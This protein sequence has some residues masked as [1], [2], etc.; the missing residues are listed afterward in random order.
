MKGGGPHWPSI[1]QTMTTYASPS[2]EPQAVLPYERFCRRVWFR[3][4]ACLLGLVMAGSVECVAD[5]PLALFG[6]QPGYGLDFSRDALGFGSYGGAGLGVRLGTYLP[7]EDLGFSALTECA[8]SDLFLVRGGLFAMPPRFVSPDEVYR[9]DNQPY[10]CGSYAAGMVRLSLADTGVSLFRRY[11]FRDNPFD[12]PTAEGPWP[13]RAQ[14]ENIIILIHGWN[15]KGRADQYAS[16][17]E[18]YGDAFKNLSDALENNT[19]G[20][21]VLKYHWEADADTGG[22]LGLPNNAIEAALASFQHGLHLGDLLVRKGPNLRKVHFVAHSAGSWMARTAAKYLLDRDPLVS[23]T[24]TLLDPFIPGAADGPSGFIDLSNQRMSRLS[25]YSSEGR[26]RLQNYYSEDDKGL[27][28]L[29]GTQEVFGWQAPYGNE[30]E[31]NWGTWSGP[32]AH[33]DGPIQFY[34]DTIQASKPGSSIPVNLMG[35][36]YD[37]TKVGWPLSPAFLEPQTP[38]IAEVPPDQSVEIGKRITFPCRVGGAEAIELFKDRQF[39]ERDDLG[40]FEFIA[41]AQSS[42]TYVV[43]AR[44][45]A[46]HAYS[47][48]IRVTAVPRGSGIAIAQQPQ[49]AVVTV[50][51]RATFRVTA[52]GKDL[53]YQWYRNG[54]PIEGGTESSWLTSAT[55][56]SNNGYTYHVVVRNPNG[57]VRSQTATLTVVPPLAPATGGIAVFLQPQDAV[58]R[59]A[60]WSIGGPLSYSSGK[61]L[62]G[63]TPGIYQLRF[64]SVPGFIHPQPRSVTVQ[65][66]V[67]TTVTEVYLPE[68]SANLAVGGRGQLV[69]NGSANP[70]EADG[71]AWGALGLDSPPSQRPFTLTSLGTKDLI[72]DDV[73]PITIIGDSDFRVVTQPA[74]RLSPGQISDFVLEFKPRGPGLRSAQVRIAN[75]S[76]GKNPYTFTVS[77]DVSAV[78]SLAVSGLSNPI[79]PDQPA[80]TVSGTDFGIVANGQTVT[81]TFVLRNQGTA[82]LRFTRAVNVEPTSSGF[83]LAVAPDTQA[84]A[85]GKDLEIR[86][87]FTPRATGVQQGVLN[88]ESNDPRRPL[89]SIPLKA[90][91]NGLVSPRG[92]FRGGWVV[93][94]TP[95]RSIFKGPGFNHPVESIVTWNDVALTKLIG[96]VVDG[97]ESVDEMLWW[98]VL[99]EGSEGIGWVGELEENGTPALS[100]WPKPEPPRIEVTYGS[101]PVVNGEPASRTT[102]TDYGPADFRRGPVA[103]GSVTVYNRGDQHL[104]FTEPPRIQGPTGFAISKMPSVTVLRKGDSSITVVTAHLNALGEASCELV[105]PTNDPQTPTFRIPLRVRSVLFPPPQVEGMRFQ[106]DGRPVLVLHGEVDQGVRI[107]SSADLEHWILLDEGRFGP[108]RI[109]EFIDY[110]SISRTNRFYRIH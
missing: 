73:S 109:A 19:A 10:Q 63:L 12:L 71:T 76:P 74:T 92:V 2:P 103:L 99:W 56:L 39:V 18:D 21:K 25:D 26:L 1:Q 79:L 58:L 48:N 36:P 44:N 15:R 3:C 32:Y 86:V 96:Q 47:R 59:G 41:D 51:E 97:P 31:V 22:E 16:H 69:P 91:V 67:V 98:K 80:S 102:G 68:P 9:P 77:A 45:I 83:V 64:L 70:N 24:V 107:E 104:R 93:S 57:E 27:F 17:D 46:G 42:G 85:A 49:H 52:S 89:F 100:V 33:H 29:P 35:A 110:M 7:G 5:R 4:L 60:Y 30:Q 40:N 95:S 53:T 50:G 105:L 81:R 43:R 106:P 72:L 62:D 87:D 78:P 23:I 82:E 34:A 20:W 54:Q 108:S 65:A 6:S 84:L 94:S 101:V 11:Y 88:V 61:T 13:L 8:T 75:N 37:H 90:T 66:G 38:R 28:G 55:T 14:D